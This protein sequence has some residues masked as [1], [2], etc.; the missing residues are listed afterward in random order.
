M[1]LLELLFVYLLPLQFKVIMIK[2]F[3]TSFLTIGISLSS[4]AQ[5]QQHIDYQMDIQMDVK[6]FQYK[7]RQVALYENHSPDTLR[8]VFY[9][10]YLNAFQPGSQMDKNMQQV[11]DM[12]ARFMHNAGTEAEP[13]YIS[14]LSMLKDSEQGFIRLQ[15]LT[16]NGKTA[17]Y[18]VIGTILQVTL[19][20][21]ILP[22]GKATLSMDYTAQIPNIGVRMGR[23]S[24]DGVALSLSQWYPRICVY[25]AQ[26]WHPYQYIFGEFYGD[27]A[28]FDVKITLDKNYVVAGTGTLQNPEQIGFGYNNLKEVKTRE[29]TRTWH[30][31]AEK[32]IDF[33]W[34]ADPAY[35]HDIVKTKRGVE[36][37][38][39]YKNFPENWKKLQQIMP[40]VL[41]FYEAKVGKY[42]WSHYSFI[43]AGQGAMEYAMCTFIEG[44]KDP[45]ALIKT[46][47]HELAHTWFQHI[48][49]IDEQQ[50]PWFDE[51]FT[52]FLQLWAD[53]EVVKKEPVA[54]FSEFRHKAFLKYVS[55]NQ[56]EDP[57][58]RADFFERSRSYFSTAY[59]KGT[60]FAS[61]LDY[62]I[63]RKAMERTFKRFYKEYAFTHPTPENF[64]RCAEKESG[65][66]L[67]W[68]LKEF[69]HTTHHIGYCIEKVEAKGEKTLV[70]LTKKGRI[71]MPLDLIVIPNGQKPFSLYIPT[72]LTFGEKPNPF[73]NMERIVLPIWNWA[74]N[75]YQFELNLPFTQVRNISIDPQEFMADPNPECHSY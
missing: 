42:P 24:S 22:H 5:W 71:P 13:K 70:T 17:S 11:S 63:G 3:L 53:A 21:P 58:I 73:I 43:Q 37:H 64:V 55:E 74:E 33:S 62:I 2:F 44:G 47:C 32:V 20:E 66:Q 1:L 35:Q 40:E 57:S 52:C 15:S 23:N 36:L 30:F 38:F 75:T 31:K 10:L 59:A 56:E 25:D 45:E 51:G 69:M 68:F 39:F 29:K 12:P 50:Y 14:K 19:P 6:T 27:W 61:H 46:A 16:Q 49:A 72:D 41:D 54:N 4:F 9:H 67:F 60:M 65:M 34:A 28:N 26:G 18:K 48:F 8:T 7:G